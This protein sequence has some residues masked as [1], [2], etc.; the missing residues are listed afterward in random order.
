M[1]LL[2]ALVASVF[3]LASGE[4]PR[5]EAPVELDHV[6]IVVSPGAP[7]RAALERAGFRVAPALNR[8]EGQGTASVTVELQNAFLE[9]L[10]P[11]SSVPVAPGRERAV[12]VFRRRMEWRSTGWSPLGIGLRRTGPA[13]DS[14]PF[15]VRR[16]TGLPWMRPGTAIELLTAP[17]DSLGPSVW[18][19]PEYQVVPEDSNARAVRTGSARA[20]ELTHPNGVRR[21]TAAR[22]TAPNPAGIHPPARFLD[23]LG[24][25][26]LAPGPEWL[27]ELTFDD[28]AQRR[29]ADLRP[30]LPLVVRY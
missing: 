10:W 21:L 15:P 30:E 1:R 5:A 26:T 22:M 6:W 24:I 27:L 7:E 17:A 12:T 23:S 14:L 28:A 20:W 16:L 25:V 19:V 2:A 13:A 3:V 4:S 11:D 9:L 29:I 18:I 8:H